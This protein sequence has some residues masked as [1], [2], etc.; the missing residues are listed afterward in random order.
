MRKINKPKQRKLG[1]ELIIAIFSLL[2]I[3]AALSGI[4]GKNILGAVIGVGSETS[5][6]EELDLSLTSDYE[7]TLVLGNSLPIQSVMLNG[8]ITESGSARVYIEKD[9][10]RYLLF[11]QIATT[12]P[13]SSGTE[14]D[15]TGIPVTNLDDLEKL[16]SIEAPTDDETN[17]SD[18]NAS[19]DNVIENIIG[20]I[21][22]Y[23]QETDH[24]IDNDGIET[25][26]GVVDFT[27][28]NT[29]FNW[30][31]D[32]SKL[33]TR[34]VTMSED[35]GKGTVVCYGADD[36]CALI[37][38]NPIPG[39]EWNTPFDS[40][41]GRYGAT[42]ENTISSQVI[43]ADY[44]IENVENS[45]FNVAH[46]EWQS[47]NAEFIELDENEIVVDFSGECDEDCMPYG[48]EGDD[49]LLIIEVDGGILY[50]EDII[51]TFET[52]TTPVL[53]VTN[54]TVN[55]TNMTAN[56]TNITLNVTNV[57]F[58]SMILDSNGEEVDAVIEF[59]DPETGNK[60]G[61]IDLRKEEKAENKT[62]EEKGIKLKKGK[63]K[64][65]ITFDD[66][67][68]ESIDV[69][70][71]YIDENSTE[72]LYVDEVSIE[73]L[74]G[75]VNFYAIDPTRVNFTEAT[76]TVTARGDELYKC[77][78]WDFAQQ[79][80]YG[81][82]NLLRDDLVPGQTY[83]FTLTP[84]D[85]GFVERVRIN[86]C[87]AADYE[88]TGNSFPDPCDNTYPGT[89][90]F[91]DDTTYETHDSRKSGGEY[92]AG[93]RINSTNA[94]I[95]DCGS[96]K[97]VLFCYKWWSN[98]AT[99]INC[100]I[101]VDANAGASYTNITS[102]C[103]GITEPASVTCVNVTNKEPWTCS[104]FFGPT[105]AWA[106]SRTQQ[107]NTGGP[108]V[109]HTTTWD[110]FYFNVTY[111]LADIVPPAI[112]L[113]YPGPQANITSP[114]NFN[115]TATD[116]LDTSLLCNLTI[117]GIVNVTGI[118]TP[119]STATNYSVSLAD[120]YYNWSV[121]C[122]DGYNYN[123]S[124]T[125][126]FTADTTGPEVTIVNPK[127]KTYNTLQ[128]SLLATA[129][130]NLSVDT[131]WYS[132]NAGAN[133]TFTCGTPTSITA[134][135]GGNNLIV[136]AND[137]I[138]N[139]GYGSVSFTV[140]TSKVLDMSI[141]SPANGTITGD[142]TPEITLKAVDYLYSGINYTLYVYYS[143]GTFYSVGNNGTLN[144]N[145]ETTIGLSP[146]LTLSGN[147]TT[148]KIVAVG[149]DGT[150]YENS[151]DLYI[152]VVPPTMYLIW[153][154][155][156]YTDADGD[157]N[158][159]FKYGSEIYLTANCSLYINGVYN[160]ENA[161]TPANNE[162]IFAVTGL[163]EGANQ[164]WTV[165]C[166]MDGISI[167]DTNILHVD[168]TKPNIELNAP[169]N[170]YNTTP[171]NR[172]IVFNWTARDNIDSSMLC[173][174]TVNGTNNASKVIS[175]NNTAITFALS[176]FEAGQYWWNVTCWDDA[177]QSNTSETRRFN[178][179]V[180]TRYPNVTFISQDPSDIDTFDIFD[181]YLNITY[182][183]TDDYLL[184]YSSIRLYYK[185]NT[186][187]SDCMIYYN[188]S[189]SI[190]GYRESKNR[191]N[192][193]SLWSFSLY[194]NSIYPAVYNWP[195]EREIETTP[196]EIWELDSNNAMV[197]IRFFNVSSNKNY[198]IFEVMT[199][200]TN[201]AGTLPLRIYYCNSS[202]T[203]GRVD[204]NSN[205]ANF[206]NVPAQTSYNHSHSDDSKH[207]TIPFTVNPIT[208]LIGGV[209]VTPVSYFILRGEQSTDA[210]RT[211]YTTN[212][213]RPDTIQTSTNRG[214]A[215]AN[216]AG[217]IDAHLHQYSGSEY[218]RY[219]AC[220]NDTSNN[221]NCSAARY[222]LI[223]LAGLP[224]IAPYVYSPAEGYY[225]GDIAIN[226]TA[227][228][229]PNSYD[230]TYYN[231]TLVNLNLDY[232]LSIKENNSL[233]IGYTWDS[234]AASDGHY[235][236]SVKICDNQSQCSYGY[237]ENITIDNTKPTIQLN[238]PPDY[239]NS[240]AAAI[241]FNWTATNSLFSTLYC[242]LTLDGV[243][244]SSNISVTGGTAYNYSIGP[245]STSSHVWN[246]TCWDGIYNTNTSETRNFTVD[247][248]IPTVALIAPPD[249]AVDPDS[250]ITFNC[251]SSDNL[252]LSRI[253]LYINGSL[254][255]THTLT[256]ATNNTIFTVTNLAEGGY[257]WTCRAYDW[258][259]NANQS[260]A[261]NLTVSTGTSPTY[262]STFFVGNTTRWEHVVDITNICNGTAI[263]DYPPYD[264]VQWHGCINAEGANFN[265]NVILNWN[266]VTVLSENL[267]SS[268]NS[269][270]TIY[271]RNLTWD[272]P[273]L[274]Y[275]NNVTY[276]N[277][278]IC[279]N[280]TYDQAAGIVR[281]N[282][283][284]F[285]SYVTQGNSRL[286]IYD[287][288]DAGPT[289][290]GYT[291][292]K[293][294]QTQFYGNYTKKTDGT[295][296]TSAL[297]YINFTDA[298][299]TMTYNTTKLMYEYNR[300]FAAN[301]TYPYNV[302][303]SAAGYT[304][305]LLSD[306]VYI[307]ADLIPPNWS[308]MAVNV[309]NNTAFALRGYQFNTSWTDNI[310]MD[311]VWIE[312][313]FTGTITNTTI[314][315]N[316]NADGITYYYNYGP[317]AAGFYYWREHANDT[318]GNRNKT[319]MSIYVIPRAASSVNLLMNGTDG[320]Y[321]MDEDNS[322]NLTGLLVT[323]Q[324]D[325]TL[326]E[327][328]AQINAGASPLYTSRTYNEPGMYNITLV[329]N[330][331]EN[332]TSNYETHWI[333]VNDTT[334]PNVTILAPVNSTTYTDSTI[335]LNFTVVDDSDLPWVGY[336]LNQ[337]SNV[338]VTNSNL[339]ITADISD[340][341]ILDSTTYSNQN[342]NLSQSFTP[343]ED[344][345]IWELSL[346]IRRI[347][348]GSPDPLR[349][350]ILNENNDT[351]A[352]SNSISA[353]TIGTSFAWVDFTLTDTLHLTANNIYRIEMRAGTTTDYF[354]WEAND[355]GI[356]AGGQSS[357]DGA[358]QLFR[359]FDR[360]RYRTTFTAPEG[361]NNV[362]VYANDTF[363]N[364]NISRRVYFRVD[365]KP[366]YWSNN[367]SNVTSGATFAERGYQFNITWVELGTQIEAVWIEHNFTGTVQNITITAN[368]NGDIYYYNYGT[369]QT[370]SYY[371]KQY[372]ND[373][374][375]NLNQTIKFPYII[376]K[377]A[378][379]TNLYL[380]GSQANLSTVYNGGFNATGV[381]DALNVT[382]YRNG[383]E[384]N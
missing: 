322:L 75:A 30:E 189:G 268:F 16:P 232:V 275:I 14:T 313:N 349:I 120:G 148:Y 283:T 285:T 276:C 25:T 234:T 350:Y 186:S 368:N 267:D 83:T 113:N 260:A 249:Q 384:V 248:I 258:V 69:N 354:R 37:S 178:V 312:H 209:K 154:G 23:K 241:Q 6:A 11:E 127:N 66:H 174:L 128:L 288:T 303:C 336:S 374:S 240:S 137:T 10:D 90:L 315:S 188:G 114:V 166:L 192:V 229:S 356:Y 93:I 111:E 31:V 1:E 381:T 251:S 337:G 157:I 44:S 101:S 363:G 158:F 47:L 96:I 331:T 165:E 302:T 175:A 176:G 19:E 183:I 295:P 199:N 45:Y 62:K 329:Y 119:N 117:N 203:T 383:T 279:Q 85:P 261:F 33:C 140:N 250:N 273:P 204:Q 170:D 325:L 266:N 167:S 139:K 257:N 26:E 17:A 243:V 255:Q 346:R 213:S 159:R 219:Y 359:I 89:A 133:T 141:V 348:T 164:N 169:V 307:S 334:P 152:T 278:T 132:L 193:S 109:I 153:P 87:W 247:S 82:W 4:S 72:F 338:T 367:I 131:C 49:Y 54:A 212:V 200:N 263:L 78:E 289:Y 124:E 149:Y 352:M 13:D 115:W 91:L 194:D 264:Q 57:T 155:Y 185:T 306:T 3:I 196:H 41:Y 309:T 277:E 162:T 106:Q 29:E 163:S 314:T 311:A 357:A 364:M 7:Q 210:W 77:R 36:C 304:T 136:Y 181:R 296:I 378:T 271:I 95:T 351:L 74:D 130:D 235:Y 121:T 376:Q 145:T 221:W 332:Y 380:N 224:P 222:D 353:S 5:L 103:P 34:W 12:I 360:Y 2:L 328:G 246:V 366:P 112:S 282:V 340:S 259:D 100:N 173:N 184:N 198:S 150:Y 67:I 236:I 305:I 274:I 147:R 286:G 195:D 88:L 21:L 46:S 24:D 342:K 227:A 177:Y 253:E 51:F 71:M 142:L 339:N 319:I 60:E 290:G 172:S 135:E 362:T 244:N 343:L 265:A 369:I 245:F 48:L 182:N 118:T 39:M 143:N 126:M 64:A 361:W 220:A 191:V 179:L 146:E 197:K 208:G 372:A 370:G 125:R 237:S 318:S 310:A 256:G 242:N 70:D 317:I 344:M 144:N 335:D 102:A 252:R 231:I 270:A 20:M 280:I 230:L 110:V 160:Q 293:D 50:L 223:D 287:Q 379:T 292:Y 214:T 55:V 218:F 9:G 207:I 15:G 297:C 122:F 98:Q 92:Y 27:V 116:N 233:N 262:N 53:N 226:Y 123:T 134:T 345:D 80:C 291:K 202:Y 105:G 76:V 28:E 333:Q 190:C 35:T 206:Y 211:Y 300:T 326:Y 187:T 281:F 341:P 138:N 18:I 324:G 84:D 22:E 382:L 180:D 254:N 168:K 238:Y 63:H 43:F 377:T 228:V 330:A 201:I 320:N 97:Q 42:A 239:F 59:I 58:S 73:K 347:G 327:N 86:R 321:S 79:E 269:S 316:L 217:T 323:G 215:W 225:N 108:T 38:L 284:H 365:A 151:S 68:I 205:C 216:L 299:S 52:E 371:W 56:V 107:D 294:Q 373:S 81:E 61:T 171:F 94:S 358:D 8:T 40:Y 298:S 32:E 104:N 129:V 301:G 99:I 156:G 375:D 308:S 355:N 272:A 161:T 65:R